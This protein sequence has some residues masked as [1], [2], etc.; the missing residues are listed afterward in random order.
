MGPTGNAV[1]S[2]CAHGPCP[3]ARSCDSRRSCC[4]A[5]RWSAAQP[6]PLL[7][8][9][10]LLLRLVQNGVEQLVLGLYVVRGDNV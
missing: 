5:H 3:S 7:L 6:P 8:L 4:C 2:R 1:L 10:L 9:L